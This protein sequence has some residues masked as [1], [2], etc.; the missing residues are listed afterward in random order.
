MNHRDQRIG[1][2]G[3]GNMA[4]AIIRGL[5][6]AGHDAKRIL[7]SEPDAGRRATLAAI[8]PLQLENDNTAVAGASDLLVLAVKPQILP[9]VATAI[10]GKARPARQ[11]ILSI[12]AGI[13]LR[14]LQAWFGEDASIVRCMPNH[15]A[16]I[17]AGISAM[18]AV[19]AVSQEQHALAG[20]VAA[21]AG[22]VVWLADESL[23]DAI[24][25]VSGSGPAYFYLLAE[26]IEKAAAGLGLPPDLASRLT[27]ETALG[28]ARML[29]ESSQDPAALRA[30]VTSPGGTTAAAI[31]VFTRA[32]LDQLV[33]DALRSARDRAAELGA[34][35]GD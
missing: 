1:L 3:G 18:V 35:S 30:A 11:V 32:Q 25:A 13:R 8:A 22:S 27:R 19:P 10:A 23:M 20:Y 24:T 16:L 4:G 28:A 7:V 26:L 21:S 14:S 17:G 29:M 12:A 31:G 9:A 33:I 2:I 34:T 15:P 5:L 6:A